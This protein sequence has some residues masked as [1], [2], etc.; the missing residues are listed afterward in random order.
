MSFDG[1][2]QWTGPPYDS[3]DF[4]WEAYGGGAEVDY[5]QPYSM[6]GPCPWNRDPEAPWYMPPTWPGGPSFPGA[7]RAPT[8]PPGFGPHPPN[9]SVNDGFRGRGYGVPQS[10]TYQGPNNQGGPFPPPR[11]S[12]QGGN[13]GDCQPPG[14][15][16]PHDSVPEFSEADVEQ[17]ERNLKAQHDVLMARQANEIAEF[18]DHALLNSVKERCTRLNLRIEQLDE[19]IQPLIDSCT[20][21]NIS[22]GKTWV[23]EKGSESVESAELLAD[24]LLARAAVHNVSFDLRLHLI[25]LLNDLLHHFKRR[26]V[27]N[28]LEENIQR[29]VPPMFCLTSELADEDKKSKL[30]RVLDLWDSNAY[31]PPNMLEEMKPPKMDAFLSEWKESQKK[32]HEADIEKIKRDIESQYASLE[33]QHKEFSDHV[34]RQLSAA[35]HEIRPEHFEPAQ[36]PMQAT[37]PGYG[38][39]RPPG[40]HP[41]P[42]YDSSESELGD[43]PRRMHQENY[44]G[45]PRSGGS[46]YAPGFPPCGGGNWS[47]NNRGPPLNWGPPPF[48]MVGPPFLPPH[49]YGAPGS[50][51]D[52]SESSVYIEDDDIECGYD[53]PYDPGYDNQYDN[54]HRHDDRGRTDNRSERSFHHRSG[55]P[56]RFSSSRHDSSR[57]DADDYHL[58]SSRGSHSSNGSDKADLPQEKSVDPVDLVPKCPPWELPAGLMHPLIRLCDFDYSPLEESKLRLLPPKAPSERLLQAIEN[59]YLPPSHDRTRDGEG[60]ER[61]GLY[62]F[63][64]KKEKAR[65]YLQKKKK[66]RKRRSGT[67]GETQHS[68]ASSDNRRRRRNSGGS[69][70]ASSSGD[71]SQSES[72]PDVDNEHM[73][74][75]TR[76][77]SHGMSSRPTA[78]HL[79]HIT[80]YPTAAI[81]QG[82]RTGPE[83]LAQLPPPLPLGT[84]YPGYKATGSVGGQPGVSIPP[85]RQSAGPALPGI[86]PGFPSP[87]FLHFPPPS[88]S[89]P[90]PGVPQGLIQRPVPD[91]D[92]AASRTHVDTRRSP[93]KSRSL[94]RSRSGSRDSRSRSRSRSRSPRSRSRSGSRASRSRS[95]S[96]SPHS[97]RTGAGGPHSSERKSRDRRRKRSRS[98]SDSG[99][100]V[101][102]FTSAPSPSGFTSGAG[103]AGLSAARAAAL[104][105]AA[106]IASSINANKSSCAIPPPTWT[107]GP[108]PPNSF[109]VGLNKSGSFDSN[110]PPTKPNRGSGLGRSR[111]S[112]AIVNPSR[113]AEMHLLGAGPD[114]RFLPAHQ[115]PSP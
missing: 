36:P 106:S 52:H 105:A 107:G 7:P 39:W 92:S 90:P 30:S 101:A 86:P 6:S 109:G 69:G 16:A 32:A 79:S 63:Y 47:G 23:I 43:P 41:M 75:F 12:L 45:P 64:S 26:G 72:N 76:D 65:D 33:M 35:Q 114:E 18:M 57:D 96:H 2:F 46:G 100:P 17:S 70:I 77:S 83:A 78:F 8:I 14:N 66:R 40:P 58:R 97:S 94:S 56:S 34:H 3:G 9:L 115:P 99:S 27:P 102:R 29:V 85:P 74:P 98:R 55:R 62:E 59:F 11:F 71:D 38:S 53:G 87:G 42:P 50:R 61:L 48:Q 111:F 60:W 19:V 82:V 84:T 25:Y 44:F 81:G 5:P 73:R 24:Y 22:R 93:S 31:L 67:A 108:E 110:C 89:Q 49:G 54:Y 37:G 104:A 68:R 4:H 51:R 88:M 103:S 112:S 91:G 20:K 21:E 10:Y 95:R 1:G 113:V 15:S 13:F 28:H 80:A